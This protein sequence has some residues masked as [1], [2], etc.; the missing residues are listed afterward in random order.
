MKNWNTPQEGQSLA[1]PYPPPQLVVGAE[2]YL[3]PQ[4]YSV[5]VQQF[6]RVC[7]TNKGHAMGVRTEIFDG[8]LSPKIISPGEIYRVCC[9]SCGDGK[10]HLGIAHAFGTVH[11][12]TDCRIYYAKCQR[13]GLAGKELFD[14]LGQARLGRVALPAVSSSPLIQPQPDDAYRNPGECVSLLDPAY[15]GAA[16]A[17]TYLTGRGLDPKFVSEVY[18]WRF[19]WR[20]NMQTMN[21]GC[22][23]RIIMPVTRDGLEV[24]WQARLAFDPPPELKDKNWA[25]LRWL[26]MP[27]AGWRSKNLIGYDQAK[28]LDFCILVE[29][30]T[31]M[32]RQGPPCIGSLGQTMSHAQY[33]LIASTWGTGKGIVVMGDAGVLEDHVVAKTVH[34]LRQR[35]TCPVWAPRLP[36]GD[37][38][39]WDRRDF[40]QFIK[41]YVNANPRG[42]ADGQSD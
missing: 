8:R 9:P 2:A 10:Y 12:E 14:L 32:A 16:K 34:E 22:G 38:G 21:G 35:C 19:C 30:P 25:N 15:P 17:C 33:E 31:D 26:T 7:V 39:S 11:E 41:D 37:P 24:G 1:S 18:G 42:T 28:A 23:G 29:G 20:G 40:M 5:L 27:G 6:G 4:L 3:N 13:C 36:H